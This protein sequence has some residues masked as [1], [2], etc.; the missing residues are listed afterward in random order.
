MDALDTATGDDLVNGVN[1]FIDNQLASVDLKSEG[2][3]VLLK[4]ETTVESLDTV[5]KCEKA[6]DN[7]GKMFNALK[8][9]DVD[10]ETTSKA[11]N[12][13]KKTS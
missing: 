3:L 8:T 5:D 10:S 13:L 4:M 11:L 6:L 7:V 2:T 9:S 1:D 12:V